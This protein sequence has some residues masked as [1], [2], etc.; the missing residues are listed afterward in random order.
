M[1]TT[2]SA[3]VGAGAGSSAN[4]FASKLIKNLPLKYF[5]IDRNKR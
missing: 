1:L 2:L 4:Q 5:C 3:E